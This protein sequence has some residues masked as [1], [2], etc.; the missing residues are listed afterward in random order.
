MYIFIIRQQ[1]K[2]SNGKAENCSPQLSTQLAVVDYSSSET[3]NDA[4][5]RQRDFSDR[6]SRVQQFE[7]FILTCALKA[8]LKPHRVVRTHIAAKIQFISKISAQSR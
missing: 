3:T 4:T 6:I 5:K 8:R 2:A 7:D 1:T